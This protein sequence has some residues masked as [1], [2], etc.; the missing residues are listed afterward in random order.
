M[1]KKRTI[2]LKAHL[3]L[4]FCSF[5]VAIMLILWVLQIFFLSTFFSKMKLNEMKKTGALIEEQYDID[6]ENFYDF[7]FEHSFQAGMFAQL[8][9]EDGE[10]LRNFNAFPDI[11]HHREEWTPKKE[12]EPRFKIQGFI[13]FSNFQDFI[14]RVKDNGNNV[15]FVEHDETH[16]ASFA[17]YGSLLGK[18]DEKDIYL[19]LISPLE[20]TD[21]TRK[22]LETQL[23]MVSCISVL[24]ALVLAY[25]IAKRLSKPIEKT[26]EGARRLAVG[27]YDVRF[28]SGSYREID[29]LSDVLNHAAMELSKTDELRRDLISNVSHD[30][31]TPLTIIKSYAE[32]I[33]DISGDNREK[34]LKHTGVIVDEANN[35]SLLVNDMLD[36]SKIQSGTLVMEQ[37]KFD[38]KRLTVS[39]VGRFEYYRENY[40]MNFVL[41]LDSSDSIAVGDEKRIEQ[42]IYNLVANAVNYTGDDKTVVINLS[43]LGDR[44]RVS[45]CDSGCGISEQEIG[46]VWDKY[47]KASENHRRA[48][49]GTGIGLS[50]VK[51]I[52]LAHNAEFGVNS[53][54]GQGSKFWFELKK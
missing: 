31:R 12:G 14:S 47:Y 20:R 46:R 23:I 25:F 1:K 54:K 6:S 4:Y 50:I 15:A 38:H 24:L 27:D 35:L 9:T 36:L 41:N 37:Q 17:V 51:N 11:E 34:R 49:I 32:M 26:T 28:G 18:V 21:A 40:G 13:N 22:V 8:I 33:R 3:W 52:L 44:L 7:W 48:T 45:V 5:A 10:Q 53:T 29:E 19:F 43:D 30:L 39:T 42:V 2:S 16:R